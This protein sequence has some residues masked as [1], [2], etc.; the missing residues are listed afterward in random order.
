[1]REPSRFLVYISSGACRRRIC[2]CWQ[3]F[4]CLFS[5]LILSGVRPLNDSVVS[6]ASHICPEQPFK[7]II[8]IQT[9]FFKK[10]PKIF[11]LFAGSTL[12]DKIRHHIDT[13]VSLKTHRHIKPMDTLENGSRQR[14]DRIPIR[15]ENVLKV[16]IVKAL[17]I[18]SRHRVFIAATINCI[19]NAAIA[20]MW[21]AL[22]RSRIYIFLPS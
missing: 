5:S 22:K 17:K 11:T 3:M 19:D 15:G 12:R 2:S 13:I 21:L 7:A 20:I 8:V 14:I 4:G 18:N 9:D 6:A 10:F 1:M 16:L